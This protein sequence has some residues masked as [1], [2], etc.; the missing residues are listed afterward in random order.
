MN[1]D[2]SAD[3]DW[4]SDD[5]WACCGDVA[6]ARERSWL[7]RDWMVETRPWRVWI[8]SWMSRIYGGW[9]RE[10]REG[11]VSSRIIVVYIRQGIYEPI[12]RS[13]GGGGIVPLLPS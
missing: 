11:M 5:S 12:E 8:A 9:S 3:W 1:L 10:G 4:S 7:C 13:G 2:V 6:S